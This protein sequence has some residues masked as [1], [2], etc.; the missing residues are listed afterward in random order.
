MPSALTG[1][2]LTTEPLGKPEYVLSLNRAVKGVLS[3]RGALELKSGKELLQERTVEL[4]GVGCPEEAHPA[5]IVPRSLSSL[6]DG[7][8]ALLTSLST[9]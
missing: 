9:P 7:L 2:F 1:G 6:F 5:S 4:S 3:E 8:N